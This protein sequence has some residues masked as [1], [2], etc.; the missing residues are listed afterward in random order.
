VSILD[1]LPPGARAAVIRL[2]SLGDCVLTTPALDILKRARPDLEIAVVVEDRFRSVFEGNPDVA[3]ILPPSLRELRAWKPVLCLNLH[4]GTR[5]ARL[6]ALCGARI[7][8]GFEHFPNQF[9]YNLRI[10]KAQQILGTARKV[11]TAEHLASAAF[12]LGAPLTAIPR[13]KLFAR[14]ADVPAPLTVIHPFAAEPAKTWPH[15]NFLK[16]AAQLPHVV[17]IGGPA[18]D[19]TAFRQYPTLS[20]APLDEIK[21]LL[22]RA[23]LFI[24]NDSG[25]AHMA[26]AFGIPS[27]VLFAASDPVIWGPWKTP[28]EVLAA[29]RIGSITIEQVLAALDRLRVPA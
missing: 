10:P 19:F 7:R 18:D 24:G 9:L 5:S 23:P 20:G 14:A 8:A 15:A 27:V 2:R 17:F 11:H 13:A 26:A 16:I 22:A 1:E 28:A 21:S 29:D 4:G 6:T 12:H 25:P 3:C